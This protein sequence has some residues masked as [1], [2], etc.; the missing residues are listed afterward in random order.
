VAPDQQ[1]VAAGEA[2]IG[3]AISRTAYF[4][5]MFRP[6]LINS[7]DPEYLA[8]S[9]IPKEILE[10]CIRD[11]LQAQDDTSAPPEQRIEATAIALWSQVH[12]FATLWLAGNLGNPADT[13]LFDK[14][15]SDML[16]SI[17]P[18]SQGRD[19]QLPASQQLQPT[20]P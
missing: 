15:V 13:V 1:L 10:Q 2:Y 7:R 16:S 4:E 8:A 6:A 12:G 3:F 11:F 5:I 20:R 9:R 17:S 19:A 14:M 18:K